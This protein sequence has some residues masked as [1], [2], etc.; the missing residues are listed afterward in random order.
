MPTPSGDGKEEERAGVFDDLKVADFAWVGVGPLI[1][2]AL[3]D[4]GATTVHVESETR[5]DMLRQI[6]PFAEGVPGLNR[7]QFFGFVNT[8]KL[9]LACDLATDAGRE[10]ALR[11]IDWADVVIE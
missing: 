9:S 3:A 4:Q 5:P 1:A 7:S 11:M 10:L 2:R 6:G 8:S